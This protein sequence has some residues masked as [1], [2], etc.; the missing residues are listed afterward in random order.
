LRSKRI[1]VTSLTFRGHVT[2]SVDHLVH[3]R[4][5]PIGG[6]LERSLSPAD[7]EISG[8]KLIGVTRIDLSGSRYAIEI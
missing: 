5:L 7:F 1:E 6:T 3:H 8:S 2:T 4:P